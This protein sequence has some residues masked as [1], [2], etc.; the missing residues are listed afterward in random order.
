M[1]KRGDELSY[2]PGV[3]LALVGAGLIGLGY[4]LSRSTECVFPES[5]PMPP[6]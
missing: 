6:S 3:V 4:V 2:V 1:G 5:P